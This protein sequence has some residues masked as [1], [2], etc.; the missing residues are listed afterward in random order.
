[1]Q[2]NNHLPSLIKETIDWYRW[3]VNLKI[4]HEEYRSKLQIDENGCVGNRCLHW[5]ETNRCITCVYQNEKEHGSWRVSIKSFK[6]KDHHKDLQYYYYNLSKYYNY[7]SGCDN[8]KGYSW[9]SMR[10]SQ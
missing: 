5:I 6:S 3:K 7:T 2:P 1:M 9:I 8:P 4:L 10:T